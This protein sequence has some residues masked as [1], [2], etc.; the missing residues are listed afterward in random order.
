M[1]Y[2]IL[3][4]FLSL[5]PGF[6]FANNL[7]DPP[8]GDKSMTILAAV[9]GSLGTFGAGGADPLAAGIQ[10]FNGGVLVIGG[11]LV[12]Y[13]I[14][15]GTIGT[16]H[17]GEMLGKK[18]S[19]V[20]VPIRT[21]LGTALVLPV[22]GGSYCTMQAIVG[23][24]IV[25]GIGLADNVWSSFASEQ[26]I[27]LVATQGLTSNE[28]TALGY[29]LFLSN[30]CMKA[31]NKAL[32]EAIKDAPIIV[33]NTTQATRWK[34]RINAMP[35]DTY[36]YGP[37]GGGHDGV[38]EEACGK[39]NVPTSTTSMSSND[40]VSRTTAFFN[41]SQ[42]GA[43]EA[44]VL[45]AIQT[46]TNTLDSDMA[47]LADSLVSSKGPIDP[48][49]IDAAI[50]RYQDTVSQAAT[51]QAMSLS[52]FNTLS[53]NA[54]AD[55]WFMAGAF[56]TKIAF[57]TDV[58]QRAMS[59]MAHAS[60]P[61]KM[62]SVG[63]GNALMDY[64]DKYN[65]YAQQSIKGSKAPSTMSFG[66]NA[67]AEGGDDWTF[68][69]V[70]NKLFGK[71][72]LAEG[73]MI[74][75]KE[76]PLIAMKRIGNWLLGI[77]ASSGAAVVA[78][79][80]L[81]AGAKA[82]IIGKAVDLFGGGVVSATGKVV[83]FIKDFWLKILLPILAVGIFLSYIL[84]M[85]PYMLWLGA[86][87]GW[88]IM[89]IEAI[90]AAPM[91]AVMHLTANG[92]DMVGSGGQGYRLVLSLMLRPVLMIFGLIAAFVI[93]NVLGQ[94]VTQVFFGVF[95]VAQSD[96]GAFIK[97]VG[98]IVAPIMYAFAMYQVIIRSFHLIHMIPDELLK[99]F[100]GGG[101]QLG[102]MAEQMGGESARGWQQMGNAANLAATGYL[103]ANMNKKEDNAQG[104]KLKGD[105]GLNDKGS[106]LINNGSREMN[107]M[108]RSKLASA[109]SSL[110]GV[111]SEDGA[112]FMRSFNEHAENGASF[113]E[114]MAAAQ[115]HTNEERYGA[116]ATELINRFSGG[117]SSS[118]EYKGVISSLNNKMAKFI[119]SSG[120]D[121]VQAKEKMQ[122]MIADVIST[123][124]ANG[125][126]IGNVLKEVSDKYN[127]KEGTPRIQESQS[128][129]AAEGADGQAPVVVAENKGD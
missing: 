22:I 4:I 13:T 125:G 45:Q 27:K 128:T 99:W 31:Y 119:Q 25:Q 104:L 129:P 92:D 97:L 34:S 120:G 116:G 111:E 5:I 118:P 83:D 101:T 107:Q 52:N 18:F 81:S 37:K 44:A 117:D 24:L 12:A 43:A 15:A 36:Y 47:S 55:G 53:A 62:S 19:S 39:L 66:I 63:D 26:N 70:I 87:I 95:A 86:T 79:S 123:H 46:A 88:L 73:M 94:L 56:Y 28:A 33:S 76:H 78:I 96:S 21:A 3:F 93:I 114:A 54:T 65:R 106:K 103:A 105:L 10:A 20:W 112:R 122:S 23:W 17:D 8:T 82:S 1:M 50:K 35:G 2:R 48:T 127:K 30:A 80:M 100:G 7:F 9:F 124:D 102:N 113:S 59:N 89:S 85:M 108:N 74:D 71:A 11:V 40:V 110:G 16:A 77:I 29:N 90:I 14:L 58:V 60:G 121:M 32:E 57:L 64:I 75:D 67:E 72:M 91:W 51:A 61:T 109:V 84:P 49:Q 42:A 69:T 41:V 115:N 68:D 6:A 126:K 98:L 38:P